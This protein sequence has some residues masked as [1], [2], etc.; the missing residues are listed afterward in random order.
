M[1]KEKAQNRQQKWVEKRESGKFNKIFIDYSLEQ[2]YNA[3]TYLVKEV[4]K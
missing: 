1:K 2:W 4:M 3:N